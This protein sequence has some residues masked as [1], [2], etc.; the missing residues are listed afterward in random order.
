MR[1]A[2]RSLSAALLVVAALAAG[3]ATPV[4]K[5]EVSWV[6]PKLPQTPFS[7]VLIITVASDEFVQIAFQEQMAA[8]L[9]ER[10]VNAVASRRGMGRGLDFPAVCGSSQTIAKARTVNASSA[11]RCNSAS[12]SR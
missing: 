1:H 11:S 10:G 7:K 3:C 6:S 4:T 8:Q 9:K 5:L 2:F 12:R